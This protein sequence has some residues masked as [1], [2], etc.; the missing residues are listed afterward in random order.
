ML[1]LAYISLPEWE[2]WAL[3]WHFIRMYGAFSHIG[4]RY[5]L[6]WVHQ[7]L[8]PS[9]VSH[10]CVWSSEADQGCLQEQGWAVANRST[11]ILLVATLLKSTPIFP[12]SHELP[13]D[14]QGGVGP[15]TCLPALWHTIDRFNI[16]QLTQRLSVKSTTSCHAWKTVFHSTPLHPPAP[17]SFFSI[18]WASGGWYID[19]LFIDVLEKNPKFL[20]KGIPN[21]SQRDTDIKH[22][23]LN[24][25][26]HQCKQRLHLHFLAS[27]TWII[28]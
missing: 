20:E 2:W 12:L 4:P 11:D 28:T 22:N 14:P 1:F 5:T 17:T 6:L 21:V 15:P 3:S 24:W 10:L 7:F 18:P 25:A 16:M 13:T 26:G 23:K 27:Q 19:A 9:S 8:L